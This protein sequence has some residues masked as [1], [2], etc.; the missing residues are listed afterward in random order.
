MAKKYLIGAGITSVVIGLVIG[1]V[2]GFGST[3]GSVTS[4]ETPSVPGAHTNE[5]IEALRAELDSVAQYES[6]Y[7]CMTFGKNKQP[8]FCGESKARVDALHDQLVAELHKLEQRSPEAVAEV[9]AK[10]RELAGKPS[11]NV[12]FEGTSANPYT[13]AVKRIEQ[14]RDEQGF[15]YW[16]NPTNNA[17]VQ[18]G[19]GSDKPIRFAEKGDLSVAEL[20]QKAEAYL[21]QHVAD[22]GKVKADYDFRQMSKPGNVSYA[23]RWE[24]KSKPEGEDMKPFVQVVLS[25]IGEVMSFND[26]RSLYSN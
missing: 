15:E 7:G 13:N 18:F 3:K 14:Y 20:Q 23:F 5:R 10:I 9:T 25:P 8:E 11:L 17:V 4:A 24:A 19:P 6:A 22:F 26:V 16:V 12:T 2:I 21:A 1:A